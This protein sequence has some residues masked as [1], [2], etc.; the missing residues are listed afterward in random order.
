MFK[1]FAAVALLIIIAAGMISVGLEFPVLPD[2]HAPATSV[3]PE[4][5]GILR[6]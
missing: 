5:Q 6:R 4:N 3:V 2:A 1:H